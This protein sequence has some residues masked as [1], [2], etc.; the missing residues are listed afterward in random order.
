MRPGIIAYDDNTLIFVSGN[1]VVIQKM[2]MKD[3]R[4]QAASQTYIPGIEGSEGITTLALSPCKKFLAVCEKA[5]HAICCIYCPITLKR[6]RV[7]TSN[8]YRAREFVAAAFSNTRAMDYT[9]H[10]LCTVTDEPEY[11][12]K[13]WLFDKQRF[14]AQYELVVGCTPSQVSFH[15][16][17]NT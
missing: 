9:T 10:Y 3:G 14:V 2:D 12:V 16:D 1:N 11:S 8:D 5:V 4:C 7:L 6:K 17:D 15:P 13:L